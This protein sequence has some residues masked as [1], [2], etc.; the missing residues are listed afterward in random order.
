MKFSILANQTNAFQFAVTVDGIHSGVENIPT[1]TEAMHLTLAELKSAVS[2]TSGAVTG[3]LVAPI[4][5][6]IELWGAGVTYL[7]S[8]DARKEESG[9]PDVYQRVYEA[10][11][12]ELFF[13]SNAVR[14]RG[15]NSPVGIRYDSAASVPEPEVAIYINRY[16]EII[17]YAICNDMTARTIEGENPLYL[18]QAKIYIGSTAIGPDITPAWLAPTAAEMKIKARIVRGTEIAWEA[19]TSLA[20]LNRTLED[21]I[22]YLF[23][24]QD[25]PHGVILSTGTGIVPP[26]DI[27]L[28]AADVVEIDVAGV[29][30][31]TNTV[32]VIPER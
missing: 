27:S 5:P 20:A 23:R 8:R 25:F 14:A 9:V 13:K 28:A 16:R 11:R 31:L 3:K 24:C 29:G 4:S 12:P 2:N 19:E 26:L 1:L 17:G 7:R 10:D 18:S 6:E 15:T 30:K 32:E 21:L 22:T